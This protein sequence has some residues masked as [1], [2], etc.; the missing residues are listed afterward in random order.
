LLYIPLRIALI[1]VSLFSNPVFVKSNASAPSP[2]KNNLVEDTLPS[3]TSS[4]N[5]LLYPGLSFLSPVCVF[6]GIP[7]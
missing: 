3:V 7:Q 6:L 1:S 5:I 2:D 4:K